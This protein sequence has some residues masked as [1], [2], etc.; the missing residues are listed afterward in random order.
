V[1]PKDHGDGIPMSKA[2]LQ[3]TQPANTG[4][5]GIGHNTG[6][7]F[8]TVLHSF[9]QMPD[10]DGVDYFKGDFP[11]RMIDSAHFRNIAYLKS[12]IVKH[13]LIFEAAREGIC[14]RQFRSCKML[15][16]FHHEVA[17]LQLSN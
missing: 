14:Q 7:S 2:N 8:D 11:N 9:L 13:S 15:E 5:P 16:I 4:T 17:S 10:I 12:K 6:L 3:T 1:Q